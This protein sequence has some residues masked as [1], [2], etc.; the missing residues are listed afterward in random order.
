MVVGSPV[1]GADASDIGAADIR[2][3]TDAGE[4]SAGDI[5]PKSLTEPAPDAPDAP[6]EYKSGKRVDSDGV[7]LLTVVADV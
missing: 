2:L 5:T 3:R 6:E 1:T 7:G 4:L